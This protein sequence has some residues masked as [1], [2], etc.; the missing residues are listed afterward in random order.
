M[1]KAVV[2][3]IRAYE[4]TLEIKPVALLAFLALNISDV[5]G[6]VKVLNMSTSSLT[7][8]ELFGR[9]WDLGHRYPEIVLEQFKV[10]LSHFHPQFKNVQE[11]G[12]LETYGET[13][14]FSEL[15]KS[16]KVLLFIFNGPHFLVLFRQLLV[17]LLLEV[18]TDEVVVFLDLWMKAIDLVKLLEREIIQ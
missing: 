16:F 13:S 18:R 11:K 15:V 17:E 14:A 2:L 4:L 3:K 7:L 6:P 12:W 9:W 10:I 5:R 1:L 8:W